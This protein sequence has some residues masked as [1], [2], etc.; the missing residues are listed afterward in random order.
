[1]KKNKLAKF[2]IG[3]IVAIVAFGAIVGIARNGGDEKVL[4]G[5]A[6]E[7]CRLDDTTG[8]KVKDDKSGISTKDFYEIEQLHSIKLTDETAEGIEYYVNLYDEDKTF[9]SV[10]K[11]TG[12]FMAE[13]ITAAKA[14]G[15]AF[16]KVEI[17]DTNDDEISFFEKYGLSDKVAVKLD[18]SEK[19]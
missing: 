10:E 13:D 8:K 5:T 2:A 17:V 6:Y 19:E 4:N 9:L 7:T 11:V 14:R 15:A 3:A 18:L 1:M 16:F 12:D